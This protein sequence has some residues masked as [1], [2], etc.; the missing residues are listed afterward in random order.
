MKDKA[1]NGKSSITVT[2]LV[3]TLNEIEGMKA[4]MPKIEKGWCD[5]IIVIDGGSTDGTLEYAKERGYFILN[6]K[7]KGLRNGFIESLPYVK[8]DV[9][10]TFS[11]D[12]N[13]KPEL[14]PSLIEKM[15]EG[16]DMVIVSR[17]AKGARSYDDDM[18]TGFGNWMFTRLI[19]LIYGSKYTDS[20]VI[21]R[22]YKKKIV[23]ELDLDKDASYAFE[24]KLY[25]TKI[26]L[27]PLLSIRA[28]K[29]RLKCA[30]I[31]GDEPPRIGGERKLEIIPW[32]LAYLTQVFKEIFYWR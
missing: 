8:G 2:L 13:S 32:G 16:Y 25:R 11:P 28:A 20:F 9:L 5:Q 29:R 10:I 23:Y 22:G 12:G 6:Q 14:I 7:T 3:F 1:L 17:Y 18:I 26:G 30:E 27:E 15:K 21:F 24:E 4:V 31:P 19:N